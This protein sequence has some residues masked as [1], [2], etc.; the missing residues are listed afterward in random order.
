[1]K[2][3]IPVW[4]KDQKL[5]RLSDLDIDTRK[6]CRQKPPELKYTLWPLYRRLDLCIRRIGHEGPHRSQTREWNSGDILSTGREH[7]A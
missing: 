4:R 6:H 1:M 2:K 3:R 7:K 5:M